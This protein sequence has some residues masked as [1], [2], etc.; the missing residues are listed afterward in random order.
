MKSLPEENR[1]EF[2]MD[3]QARMKELVEVLN[4]ASRAY[5][6]EDREVFSN[7]EYDELYDEL[8]ALEKET[9]IVMSQSPTQNVGY[10]VLSELEKETHESPM[11]SLDKTKSPEALRDWL[12]EREGLL[13]WKMDGL[14]VVLTYRDGILQKAVTRG[15]GVVGEVITNN[16]RVFKNLPAKIPFAG[17]VV[18]RGEAVIKYS[19]FRKINEGIEDVDARYKNPRNLC[20][21]SVRQ[22]NNEVTARRN[23]FFFAF[24]LVKAEGREL[25]NSVESNML[26]VQDLGFE[27]VPY[28][29]VTRENIIGEVQQFSEKIVENDFPSDGLV[30]L[31]RTAKF[32]R[33]AIA[34]KWADEEAETKLLHI[35]WSP[36]RTGLIN[37]IAVFEPVELEGTTVSRA[38]LHNISIMEGLEL[39]END[40]IK[41]YKANMI[42]PQ[43]AENLTRS[44]TCSPI[45]HCPACGGATEVR[46]ENDVKTLYC[47]NPYCSAKKVKLFSHYVSRDAM[48]IEGLSEATLMK[49]IEQ[50][51]LSEL[52][53]LY[54]LEQ[55][56][57]Q[58]I[59]MD[60]FGEK[61]YNNLIQS[62][63]KSRETQLFRFVY[64]IGILNVGSS[65]AKLLCRHFGNSL[66]NLRGASVEEM[67]QIDGIGGVIAASVR[68]YFD[69]IHNQK[70]L[71]KLLPYL[72]FEVE[73]ISAEGEA[74]QSLLDKTFVITG[75]VEHFANRKELKEK[76][77]SLGGK[78]TGSV[79]KKTDYLINNDTMS[80]SSKN[81]KAKELGIPVIT[82]E[83][84]LSMIDNNQ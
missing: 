38:S 14:T 25:E 39:G 82:E 35:E 56:K 34:F 42:I 70:L 41:V 62:I 81:K 6:Q 13:S 2:I 52:N 36:S 24:A 49:M 8:Q 61:S 45:A 66:E 3:K 72:H 46:I 54:T 4:K 26:W 69:N 57:E 20:S 15:N 75:T 1:E 76:I 80:S 17:E 32:P 73:N 77:E 27:I 12:G 51:F 78:V 28:K 11:L 79:S 50:G 40:H 67:T 31:G 37:P 43:I 30:L 23:V 9:G 64:G 19:D 48:D 18:L 59:A 65:N 83:E 22:L 68:D 5:Y 53:D 74:A 71:E 58:I 55:Y 7:K 84:F 16:A 44:G 10:E 21:G 60:G 33:N 47:V 29:R 63:E